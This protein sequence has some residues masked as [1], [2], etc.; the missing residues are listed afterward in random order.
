MCEMFNR[1]GMRPGMGT[2]NSLFQAEATPNMCIIRRSIDSS[3]IY[4]FSISKRS[5]KKNEQGLNYAL[6]SQWKSKMG[7]HKLHIAKRIE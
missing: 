6:L 3:S 2:A 4:L 7:G 1:A 5:E